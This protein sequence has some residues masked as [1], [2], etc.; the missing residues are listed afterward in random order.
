[1]KVCL[2]AVFASL[3]LV[4]CGEDLTVEQQVIA[5]LRDMEVAAES[6]EHFAFMTYVADGFKG[7]LGSMDRRAFHRFMIFQINQHR[8]LQAQF[9]PIRVQETGGD[10]ATAS[11]KLLVTGGGGLLPES[12]RVFA[13][14]T[15]WYR[16]DGDWQLTRADWEPVS[17]PDIP[18]IID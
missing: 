2:A 8:R 7:Q 12:G 18:N 16:D 5:T 6:G 3:L 11:F 17:L 15:D 14:E 9:F 10:R 13:V 1:M 4:S